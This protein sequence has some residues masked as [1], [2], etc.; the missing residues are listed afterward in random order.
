MDYKPKIEEIVEDKVE[1]YAHTIL[2]FGIVFNAWYKVGTSKN[3]G[4]GHKEA[5]FGSVSL[6]I[7]MKIKYESDRKLVYWKN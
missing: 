7:Y 6:D 3:I 5:L 4:E 1:F 2:K